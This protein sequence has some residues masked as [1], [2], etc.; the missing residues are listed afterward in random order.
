MEQ[1]KGTV[2]GLQKGEAKLC[3][4][5]HLTEGPRPSGPWPL[6]CGPGPALPTRGTEETPDGHPGAR[7]LGPRPPAA[8][9]PHLLLHGW[10]HSFRCHSTA[11]HHPATGAGGHSTPGQTT[12]SS[13]QGC[14]H[15]T[16]LLLRAQAA[17]EHDP[18][19]NTLLLGPREGTWAKPALGELPLLAAMLG[20][21]TGPRGRA[22]HLHVLGL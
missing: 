2:E 13:L 18:A 8:A 9:S 4:R 5:E 19:H 10:F 17:R 7:P 21:L 12:G 15:Q 11:P 16:A 3:A 22:E 20:P 14:S 6:W 1:V